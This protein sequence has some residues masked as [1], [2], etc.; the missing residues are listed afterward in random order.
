M[1][2]PHQRVWKQRPQTLGAACLEGRLDQM[3]KMAS[4]MYS[5]WCR[6]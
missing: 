2:R 3:L 5:E 1:S 4:V 6:I